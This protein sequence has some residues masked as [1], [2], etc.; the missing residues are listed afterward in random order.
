M[1]VFRRNCTRMVFHTIVAFAMSV[2][3][4]PRVL[5]ADGPNDVN[6]PAEFASKAV[7]DADAADDLD[8]LLNMAESDLG[9]VAQVDVRTPSLNI[10]V[11]T[12]ARKKSTVGR[13][14]AAV[15]VVTNEMIRRSGA[16]S[17]PEVLRM[18]PGVNVARIDS[19]RWAISVRG[20]N[21]LYSSRLLVQIDGRSVYTPLFGGVFWNATDVLLED[22]QRIEVVRGPGGTVWGANAVN[23]IINIIT[24]SAKDTQGLY[25]RAGIGTY[26]RGSGSLRYGAEIADDT[27]ARAYGKWFSRNNGVSVGTNPNYDD[28]SFIQGGFRVDRLTDPDNTLTLQGDAFDGYAGRANVFPDI[29]G[30]PFTRSVIGNDR[31][32]GGNLLFRWTHTV[33]DTSDW[34]LQGSWD[35]MDYRA[36]F[37][38]G[39]QPF[40]SH[41]NVFDIDFQHRFN[42]NEANAI[43]WGADFTYADSSQQSTPGV[44]MFA[45]ADRVFQQASVFI[46]D[47]IK[48]VDDEL[49]LTLGTKLSHYSFTG[50]E[51]QPSARI[52]W[53]PHELY[54]VWASVSR[55]V[56][57]PTIAD[58]DATTIVQ[59]IATAPVGVFP[60]QMPARN[61]QAQDVM[62]Y[63]VGVRGQPTEKWSWD[64]TAFVNKY[65][66]LGQGGFT[67]LSPVPGN[68][69]AVFA[70]QPN[71]NSGSAESYGT[72]FFSSYTITD[73]WNVTGNYSYIQIYGAS[74]DTKAAPR[75]QVYLHSA[76]ELS[77]QWETDVIWRYVDNVPSIAPAY[78]VMDLRLAWLPHEHLEW[79]VVARNLG[80]NSHRE[81]GPSVFGDLTTEVPTEVYTTLTIRY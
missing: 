33:D 37:S 21:G 63:E 20:F 13:S 69:L 65:E 18:V 61:L 7:L 40:M 11:T 48:L 44:L 46:Q 4:P 79:A 64:A 38:G 78:S 39:F 80:D 56:R 25:A 59:P 31:A 35:H 10:E 57:V 54:S 2:W 12:V 8:Q 47:E 70:N 49:L 51:L 36:G 68:P 23:G 22:V 34:S 81:F 9:R 76:M 17:V 62:A 73:W 74:D 26:E 19:S 3:L 6:A 66:N 24:K 43:V 55:A 32:K 28:W 45:P 75:N 29:A 71:G 30:P 77:P 58:L 41:V 72:E 50:V 52:L 15:Y 60:R 27:F 42:L 16:L 1:D 14:P 53:L 67:G 5:A